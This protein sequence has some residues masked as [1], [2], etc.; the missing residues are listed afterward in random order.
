MK[1][2]ISTRVNQSLEV[3]QNGFTQDLFLS[4]NPP[5]PKVDLLQFDG[6]TKGDIVSL[7][8]KFGFFNQVWTSE[9]TED[10]LTENQWLFVDE[11]TQLPFFLK[12]WRHR[13]LVE[14]E[15]SRA[16]ITDDIE[17]SCGF[18]LID[19]LMWPALYLQ[20]LYRKPIYRKLFK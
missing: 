15:G 4:L 20:F 18:I 2:K 10:H 14:R 19:V 12:Q 3:V 17:F 9:I 1:L 7:K 5:F 16:V 8:L 13:H 6:C 11:G